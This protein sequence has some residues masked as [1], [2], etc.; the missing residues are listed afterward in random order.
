VPTR[1]IWGSPE[2]VTDPEAAKEYS[3]RRQRFR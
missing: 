1:A 3:S 2:I